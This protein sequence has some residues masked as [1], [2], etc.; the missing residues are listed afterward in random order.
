MPGR[1]SPAGS[2]ERKASQ[3]KE[4]RGV[5]VSES[6]TIAEAGDIQKW[7]RKVLID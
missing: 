5:E 7:L 3:K 4:R 1:S 2:V 6:A